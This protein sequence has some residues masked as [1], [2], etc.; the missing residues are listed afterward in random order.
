MQPKPK[1]M[2]LRRFCKEIDLPLETIVRAIEQGTFN[3]KH[4]LV[5]AL[6]KIDVAV[7]ENVFAKRPRRTK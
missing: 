1:L 6:P 4:G 5:G 3:D 7:Y 2:S